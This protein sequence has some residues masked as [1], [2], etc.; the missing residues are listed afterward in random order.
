MRNREAKKKKAHVYSHGSGG[1]T[2]GP[3]IID[4]RNQEI[5]CPLCDRI[6]KQKDRLN[7]HIANHHASCGANSGLLSQPS[8]SSLP[9]ESGD[10]HLSFS[11]LDVG[12]QAGFYVQKSPKMFL[13]EYCLRERR[14]TPKYKPMQLENGLWGCKVCLPDP[15]RSEK[16]LVA[17]LRDSD[18]AADATDAAQR[19]A[20][21]M[22]HRVQGDRA[23]ERVLP[24]EYVSLWEELSRASQQ[25]AEAAA[26]KEAANE[27]RREAAKKRQA[28][29][30]RK[31]PMV[32]WIALHLNHT[33]LSAESTD[34]LLLGPGVRVPW[35]RAP[36]LRIAICRLSPSARR[37][38]GW[39]KRRS[40]P[41]GRRLGR[42]ALCPNREAAATW[43]KL[44]GL[45]TAWCRRASPMPMPALLCGSWARARRTPPTSTGSASTSKSRGSLHVSGTRQ[46]RSP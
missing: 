19:A 16:D 28:A 40:G 4:K 13:H 43:R 14:P 37:R 42:D 32:A 35:P 15:K 30:A 45:P 3:P 17:F 39:S 5:Q 21:T 6:F 34:P 44:P 24:R 25:R 12:S 20:V 9:R 11:R 1:G 36:C 26:A 29:E 46:R 7:Q 18:S 38:G 8:N 27:R 10:H 33:Q 41:W 31:A 22:L 2:K 23:L